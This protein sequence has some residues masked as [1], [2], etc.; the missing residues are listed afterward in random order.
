[1]HA[2]ENLSG[3]KGVRRG[4]VTR[5]ATGEQASVSSFR[6]A[7]IDSM[8]LRFSDAAVT[9]LS[10]ARCEARDGA[11]EVSCIAR[12]IPIDTAGTL[13]QETS[14]SGQGAFRLVVAAPENGQLLPTLQ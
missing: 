2:V 1:M 14:I 8:S 13:R 7:G 11:M 5:S 4:F 12:G 3:L 10:D 6:L 9:V